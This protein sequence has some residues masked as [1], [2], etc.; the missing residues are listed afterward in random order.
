MRRHDEEPE[1]PHGAGLSTASPASSRLPGAF[2]DCR[3]VILDHRWLHGTSR[4]D[5]SSIGAFA[6]SPPCSGSVDAFRGGPCL[7]PSCICPAP[8]LQPSCIL[9]AA[10]LCPWLRPCHL[11][12]PGGSHQGCAG[13][14]AL[15]WPQM[16]RGWG[17]SKCPRRGARRGQWIPGWGSPTPG[18]FGAFGGPRGPSGKAL[19]C[20]MSPRCGDVPGGQP[21]SRHHRQPSA[22]RQNASGSEE[23]SSAESQPRLR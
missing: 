7:H 19:S 11:C 3:E 10:P 23:T 15:P 5:V 13:F 16:P 14:G 18:S 4:G 9:P 20:P 17:I 21:S 2:C 6:H 8:L 1:Q 12:A 22:R